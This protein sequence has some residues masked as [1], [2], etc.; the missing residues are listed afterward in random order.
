MQALLKKAATLEIEMIC[1][2]HGFVWRKN[3]GDFIAKYMH[4]SSYAPEE[5]GVV[6][7]YASVYGHTE[8][9]AEILACRLREKGI[10]TIM[11]DVSVTPASDIIAACFKWSHIVFASTTYNA[12]IFVNME[13]LIFDLVAHNIQNRTVAFIENGSWA[14]TSGKL[15]R[16]EIEKCKNMTILDNQLT[17]KSS[18]KREQLRRSTSW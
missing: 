13:A 14:P 10:K 2:L 7:A 5:Y 4:W 1:P 6:I 12:G 8:N 15:M 17:L 9:A 18:L 16:A 3:I 11:F